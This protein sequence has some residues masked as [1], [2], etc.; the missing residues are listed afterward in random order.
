MAVA[1]GINAGSRH[2]N[3]ATI[4]DQPQIPFGGVNASGYGRFGGTEAIFEFTETCVLSVRTTPLPTP[5]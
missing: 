1:N 3:M 4:H 5:I 2:V